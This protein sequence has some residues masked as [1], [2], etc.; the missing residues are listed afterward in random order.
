M[1]RLGGKLLPIDP[2]LFG[3]VPQRP[4]PHGGV[5]VQTTGVLVFPNTTSSNGSAP[6]GIDSR[7]RMAGALCDSPTRMMVCDFT[8][9]SL[10]VSLR[11]KTSC[12]RP[13][14]LQT[15]PPTKRKTIAFIVGGFCSVAPLLHIERYRAGRSTSAELKTASACRL[16]RSPRTDG[17]PVLSRT[18]LSRLG[19]FLTKRMLVFRIRQ[20]HVF[21]QD[22]PN[23]SGGQ[24]GRLIAV[25]LRPLQAGPA[26]SLKSNRQ[27]PLDIVLCVYN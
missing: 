1:P 27:N 8:R 4:G 25:S 18:L 6:T 24:G 10:Y 22:A 12:M 5:L 9:K 2:R 11:P 7:R 20:R 16:C 21:Y 19:V 14:R 3:N 15:L 23:P 17:M 26:A 13:R